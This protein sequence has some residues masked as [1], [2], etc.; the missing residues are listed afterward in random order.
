M[1]R[2]LHLLR[3]AKSSWDDP[4]LDDH[5]RPLAP[6]GV[7]AGR[8]LEAWLRE[9]PVRPELVL[10]SSAVR[11]QA[12]LELVRSA[13]GAPRVLSEDGLYHAAAG[14]LLD[15]VCALPHPVTEVM[16]IGHNPGLEDLLRLLAAAPG[17]EAPRLPTG[18]LA[19]L[20]SEV[21]SWEE[22][23]PGTAALTRLVLPRRLR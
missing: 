5:A 19:T 3:H 12:T 9:S 6:R 23:E 21:G 1:L 8:R 2:R 20:E 10:C 22:L 4:T 17:D 14:E 16:L 18:A 13:L 7:K 15:H 11:A